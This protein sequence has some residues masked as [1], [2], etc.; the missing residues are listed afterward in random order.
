[1]SKRTN[2]NYIHMCG[3]AKIKIS[4]YTTHIS[5][6]NFSQEEIVDIY[7]FYLEQAPIL[8][9]SAPTDVFGLKKLLEY[10]WRGNSDMSQLEGQLLKAG[11]LAHFIM[12]KADSI[13]NTLREMDLL[14]NCC[15]EHP[16]AV[17]KQES[18]VTVNED[19]SVQVAQTETRMECLF[20]HIRNSLAHGRTYYFENDNI[21]LEDTDGSKITA[22]IL[23]P[24]RALIEWISI[25]SKK[26]G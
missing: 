21:M 1:M 26:A 11:H 10:G 9:S 14:E 20:R 25:I 24:A 5:S 7:S 13:D 2:E 17:L 3:T 15:S 12:I 4:D 6:M 8:K 19:G 16:R 23:I 18:K 22:R